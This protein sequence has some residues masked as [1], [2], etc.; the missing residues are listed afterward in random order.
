[1]RPYGTIIDRADI[2]SS[3]NLNPPTQLLNLALTILQ[4]CPSFSFWFLKLGNPQ[5]PIL[6]SSVHS[7][8]LYLSVATRL[9][10]PDTINASTVTE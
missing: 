4:R 6:R 7:F 8:L 3:F 9:L 2:L 1:M 5:L 10:R